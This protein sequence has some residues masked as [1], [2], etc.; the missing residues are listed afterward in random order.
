MISATSHSRKPFAC[1]LRAALLLGA[2]NCACGGHGA[3]GPLV[4]HE[5][6][7]DGGRGAAA[8]GRHVDGSYPL[9]AWKLPESPG[10]YSFDDLK[11]GVAGV[12]PEPERRSASRQAWRRVA[13]KLHAGEGVTLYGVG[14]SVLGAHGGCS[15]P[16]PVLKALCGT[17]CMLQG[18]Q[19]AA[20]MSG[21]TSRPG[22][23]WARIGFDWLNHTWPSPQHRLLNAARAGGGPEQYASC[24][25]KAAPLVGEADIVLLEF[26]V[27]ASLAEGAARVESIVR[28]LLSRRGE[29]PA[30]MMVQFAEWCRGDGVPALCD[31]PP[32]GAPVS[33]APL[34]GGALAKDTALRRLARHYDIPVV[35]ALDLSWPVMF[36][37]VS[38]PA[39]RAGRLPADALRAPPPS[40]LSSPEFLQRDLGDGTHPTLTG[41]R[42]FGALLSLGLHAALQQRAAPPPH[43]HATPPRAA[44][45]P[46]RLPPPALLPDSR[47]LGAACFAFVQAT[48]RS[49]YAAIPGHRLPELLAEWPPVA[50]SHGFVYVE[51]ITTREGEPR[52]KPGYVA[53]APGS[54]VDLALDLSQWDVPGREDPL[55]SAP[56]A[57]QNAAALDMP[58]LREAGEADG[59]YHARADKSM[60]QTKSHSASEEVIADPPST[61][62]HPATVTRC[63]DCEVV[64]RLTLVY[65]Q[66]Y[67]RMGQLSVACRGGCACQA[68]TVDAHSA[69]RHSVTQSR[70]VGLQRLGGGACEVHLEVLPATSSG[71]HKFKLVQVAL[72]KHRQAP[73]R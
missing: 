12:F 26:G 39:A 19:P 36:P 31:G 73:R 51:S 25:N 54:H 43:P 71:G 30:L 52:W 46:L 67:E 24:L 50:S 62:V 56:D 41:T 63:P 65:L 13:G 7:D 60:P 1:L 53:Q 57:E 29:P 34:L 58:E 47:L 28:Q 4:G 61:R 72:Q 33:L 44:G 32:G 35:S 20:D 42:T 64:Y 38:L 10:S 55:Q 68:A 9:P 3:G 49:G 2:L 37:N 40:Q 18:T 17:C 14:S 8:L 22:A 69:A 16:L 48:G 27:T 6:G 70:E 5:W 11:R 66:S 21:L 45:T 59:A 15:E 23:G